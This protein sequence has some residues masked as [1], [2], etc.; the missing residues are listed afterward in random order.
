MNYSPEGYFLWDTWYMP[1][2]NLV[3]CYHLTTRRPGVDPK[4]HDERWISHCV[5]RD[6]IHWE[7]R[8]QILGPD[9]NNPDDNNH[10]FTGCAVWHEGRGYLYYCMRAT[11]VDKQA[12][13][14]A[15][16]DDGDHWTRYPHNP[17]IVPDARWYAR[18]N[19]PFP[20]QNTHAT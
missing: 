1:V 4:T 6:L 19:D 8:G 9:E 17:V 15:L 16:S 14:L 13:A 20:F 10:L 5:S 11:T 2:G 18:L 12:M 7:N 3:H